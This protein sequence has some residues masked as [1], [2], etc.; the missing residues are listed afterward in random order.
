MLS[1]T[2]QSQIFTNCRILFKCHYAKGKLKDRNQIT[3]CPLMK[4]GEEIDSKG[5]QGNRVMDSLH[6]LLWWWLHD[7]ICLSKL[8]TVHFKKIDYNFSNLILRV[9]KWDFMTSLLNIPMAEDGFQ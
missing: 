5:M 1:E 9:G 8:I 7:C 6:F 3:N 4:Q 2:I